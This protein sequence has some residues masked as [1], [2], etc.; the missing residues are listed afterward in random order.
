MKSG[1]RSIRNYFFP[2]LFGISLFF[3]FCSAVMICYNSSTCGYSTSYN[4]C[5][6]MDDHESSNVGIKYTDPP[7]LD[8]KKDCHSLEFFWDV[9]NDPYEA[10]LGAANVSFQR[11][12]TFINDEKCM[13][14]NIYL[15]IFTQGDVDLM[16]LTHRPWRY[17][18][19]I[20]SSVY[21]YFNNP[22]V[23]TVRVHNSTTSDFAEPFNVITDPI[24]GM[25]IGPTKSVVSTRNDID[26]S[27]FKCTDKTFECCKP[28]VINS[29]YHQMQDMLIMSEMHHIYKLSQEKL[30]S[31]WIP[32]CHLLICTLISNTTAPFIYHKVI[33]WIKLIYMTWTMFFIVILF[34]VVCMLLHPLF[35]YRHTY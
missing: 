5:A 27:S 13:H 35:T 6:D 14:N 29:G 10:I 15:Y 4:Y 3:D 18:I 20:G 2:C 17:K 11:E 1:M 24:I 25:G 12:R 32:F 30:D 8:Y 28:D 19:T 9:A 22:L 7:R 16:I 31:T 26:N 21:T 23:A 34:C 33:K